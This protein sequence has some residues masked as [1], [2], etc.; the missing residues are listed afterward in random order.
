MKN[1]LNRLVTNFLM[2]NGAIKVG[3][4]TVETL[5]G[6]PSSAEEGKTFSNLRPLP[7]CL[8]GKS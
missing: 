1:S 8:L 2:E 3:V 7:A 4:A 6:G 5:A